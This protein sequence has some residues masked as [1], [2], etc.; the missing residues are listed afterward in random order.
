[1]FQCGPDVF[2]EFPADGQ[3]ETGI[4]EPDSVYLRRDDLLRFLPPAA[5]RPGLQG[6]RA[7]S[8]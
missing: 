2:R 6:R 8:L 5:E 7:P 3:I 4:G 1:M